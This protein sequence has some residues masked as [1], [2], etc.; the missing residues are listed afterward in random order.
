MAV[1]QRPRRADV[2]QVK[3]REGVY[4]IQNML[5]TPGGLIRVTAVNEDGQLREVHI[6]GDFFFYPAKDL[7]DLERSL[8]NVPI[9]VEAVENAVAQFYAHRLV[10]FPGI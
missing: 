1:G 4:V 10:E 9:E 5:K 2:R 7:L 8:D 3:I 6:S